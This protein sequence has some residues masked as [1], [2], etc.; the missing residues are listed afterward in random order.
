MQERSCRVRQP[1]LR[2]ADHRIAVAVGREPIVAIRDDLGNRN[3]RRLLLVERRDLFGERFLS[4][5]F[6]GRQHRV[7]GPSADVH[8]VDH[9]FREQLFTW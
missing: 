2:T 1:A 9:L 8:L 7:D 3:G 6:L 5:C 4:G